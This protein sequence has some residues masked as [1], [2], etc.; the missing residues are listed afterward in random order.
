METASCPK[1]PDGTLI[2]DRLAVDSETSDNN[3]FYC[4]F[5]ILAILFD[6]FMAPMMQPKAY[7]EAR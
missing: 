6:M 5:R 4:F 7:M 1:H 3:L 2:H